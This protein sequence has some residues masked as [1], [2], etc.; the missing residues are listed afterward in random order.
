MSGSGNESMDPEPTSR[1]VKQAWALTLEDM[2]AIAE[3]RRAE[4][5]DVVATQSVHTTPVSKSMGADPER[6]G[7]VHVVPGNHA[8]AFAEAADRGEFDEYLA[9]RNEVEGSVFL[10]TELVDADTETILLVA[11]HY[12]RHRADGMIQSVLEEGAIYTIARTLDGTE[13]GRFRHEEWEPFV[14]LPERAGDDEG[15]GDARES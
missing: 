13:L 12:Y 1:A 11:S 15:D 4:G 5:W 2:E 3:E 8:E 7:L 6:F 9:Y 10:V 14:P